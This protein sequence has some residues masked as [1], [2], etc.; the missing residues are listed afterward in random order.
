M[1][2]QR[3]KRAG[4]KKK[5]MLSECYDIAHVWRV[6]P[7]HAITPGQ[8]SIPPLSYFFLRVPLGTLHHHKSL[9]KSRILVFNK[10]NG[11]GVL[12]PPCALTWLRYDLPVS[13]FSSREF[14][15]NPVSWVPSPVSL[16]PTFRLFI[17]RAWSVPSVYTLCACSVTSILSDS[18]RPYAL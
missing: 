13:I 7:Q 8:A 16:A 4:K 15:A 1:R 17:R 5:R 10:P 12:D 18:L 6:T 2:K 9:A 14:L 3:T 11:W